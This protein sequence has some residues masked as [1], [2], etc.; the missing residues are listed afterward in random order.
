MSRKQYQHNKFFCL[1]KDTKMYPS[2]YGLAFIVNQKWKIKIYKLE[3]VDGRIP[4]LK[5]ARFT[6]KVLTE[7][8]I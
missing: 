7:T 8:E 5:L 2:G 3:K 1:G 6:N 4:V